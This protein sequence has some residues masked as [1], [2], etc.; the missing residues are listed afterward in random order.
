MVNSDKWL[1]QAN[2][3]LGQINY[4]KMVN[5]NSNQ[6]VNLNSNQMANSKVNNI[7]FFK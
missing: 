1:T 5:L 7:L 2:G 3:L 6:M 4:N